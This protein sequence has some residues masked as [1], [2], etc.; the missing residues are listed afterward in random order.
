[1]KNYKNYEKKYIGSSD[2]ATLI[3]VGGGDEDLS[4]KELTFRE[5]NDYLAYVVDENAEIGFHY[6]KI[7]SFTHWLK[8]YDDT[9]LVKKFDADKIVV[10]RACDM[11]CIIQLIGGVNNE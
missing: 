1:M 2:Y 11:G 3:L 10:Y 9:G 6:K 4:L 7:A 5:D 8:I